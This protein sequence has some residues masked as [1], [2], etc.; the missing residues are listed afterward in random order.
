VIREAGDEEAEWEIERIIGAR[1]YHVKVEYLVKLLRYGE[2]EAS[3]TQ[4]DDLDHAQ[5]TITDWRNENP[6]EYDR[7][8]KG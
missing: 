7:L 8:H 2:H 4:E 1:K 5:E 3:W 6:D